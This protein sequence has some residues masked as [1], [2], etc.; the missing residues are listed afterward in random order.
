MKRASEA[1]FWWEITTDRQGTIISVTRVAAAG[2]DA[3]D[4]FYVEAVDEE[5]A[6][7][8]TES[9]FAAR[10]V[11]ERRAAWAQAGKCTRCGGEPEHDGGN[12][13]VSCRAMKRAENDRRYRRNKGELVSVPSRT[14]SAVL[15][16]ESL[17]MGS[18]VNTLREV[19]Q[20]FYSLPD[21]RR[22]VAKLEELIAAAESGEKRDGRAA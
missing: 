14:E 20:W 5:H 8:L 2:S 12:R 1:M 10:R 16:R 11:R 9:S 22:F 3:Y 4:I 6:R 7:K 19:L 13:C 18:R 21:K 15:R 17:Q